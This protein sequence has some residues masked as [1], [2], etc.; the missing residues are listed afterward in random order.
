MSAYIVGNAHINAMLQ[1]AD[2]HYEGDGPSYYWEGE[3]HYF[4]GHK[5]EI[6]QIL[7]DE[8]FRSVNYRYG[9]DSTPDTF[10]SILLRN[11]SPVEIIKA[12]HC[13]EYQ[14]CE[15]DDWEE[16]EAFAIVR[17]LKGRAI[18]RLPGYNASQWNIVK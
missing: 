2:P 11:Y 18:R 14:S 1:S 7:I 9:E 5:H 17:V 10:Q 6:G 4:S 3:R 12:C 8:N 13:Y 15:T 16:S